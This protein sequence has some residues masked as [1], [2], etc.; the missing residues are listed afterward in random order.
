MRYILLFLI[1]LPAFAL[2]IPDRPDTDTATFT[3]EA[4]TTRVNGDPLPATEIQ[5]YELYVS[6]VGGEVQVY[7]VQ[8]SPFTP[9]LSPGEYEAAIRTVDTDGLY[10]QPSDTVTFRVGVPP[11][12]P[13]LFEVIKKFLSDLFGRMFGAFT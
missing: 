8:S 12:P 5:G 3:W 11:E 7:E 1:S 4:P 6:P 9:D 2:E 10:S 13:S